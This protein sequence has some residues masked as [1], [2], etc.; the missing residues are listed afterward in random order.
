VAWAGGS[1]KCDTATC[2]IDGLQNDTPYS[3]TVSAHNEVGDGPAS[4]QSGVARPDQ[5]PDPPTNVTLTFDKTLSAGKQLKVSWTAAHTDGSPV[6]GYDL[7]ISPPPDSGDSMVSLGAVTA[8]TW[9]GLTNGTSYRVKVRAKNA[10]ATGPSEWSADSNAEFPAQPPDAPE[11]PNAVRVDTDLGGVATV[12]WA[13]PTVDGGVAVDSYTVVAFQNGAELKRVT[14]AGAVLTAQ[15]DQLNPKASDAFQVIATD[16][17]GDSQPSALSDVVQPGGHGAALIGSVTAQDANGTAGLDRQIRLVFTPPDP[18]DAGGITAYQIKVNGGSPRSFPAVEPLMVTGLTN[19]NSYNFQ[20]SG[21]NK[22]G[23]NP[24]FSGV[25]TP[26]SVPYGP[27]GTPTASV[28]YTSLSIVTF[29]IAPPAQNG[30]QIQVL[31][32]QNRADVPG[33][34]GDAG[35]AATCGQTVSI[36]VWAVDTAGQSGPTRSFSGTAAACPTPVANISWGAAHTTSTCTHDCYLLHLNAANFSVGTHSY[37]CGD[38]YSGTNWV[39]QNY[40][41]GTFTTDSTGS[42]HGD[43]GCTGSP[44]GGTYAWYYHVIID[45]SFITNELHG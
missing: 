31:H 38:N 28:I 17:A 12:T 22:F 30:R 6:S 35:V 37:V 39:Y 10:A 1:K 41:N 42:F 21:C 23:C 13:K 26:D 24:T 34:G 4:D 27:V 15:I 2:V 19:G 29:H 14:V 18:R 43:L 11:K 32:V 3:F 33:T 20:V 36:T 7:Q 5:R 9:D 44:V 25:T 8:Y 40:F 16:K 45:N